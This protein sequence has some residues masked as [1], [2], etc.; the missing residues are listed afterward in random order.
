M[1]LKDRYTALLRWYPAAYRTERGDEIVGTYL[2]LARPGQR[3]PRPGDAADLLAGGVRQHLRARHSLGLADALPLAGTL[4]L[5]AAA[6]LAAIWMLGVES[7]AY[8]G[9]GPKL[10]PFPTVGAAVW[11]AWLLAALASLAGRGRPFVVLAL[12]V[13][14]AVPLTGALSTLARPP[15]L[16]LV[17]QLVLGLV[18]LGV[19]RRRRSLPVLAAAGAAAWLVDRKSVV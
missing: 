3:W 16:V 17:P 19:P 1:T 4:A 11:I 15:L 7:F 5:A 12:L 6:A 8:P 13:T 10:G 2:D 18:A 14:A 9:R